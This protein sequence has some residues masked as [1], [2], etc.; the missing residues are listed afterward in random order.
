MLDGKF[1]A[2]PKNQARGKGQ[3]LGMPEKKGEAGYL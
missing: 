2:L 3:R 1:K